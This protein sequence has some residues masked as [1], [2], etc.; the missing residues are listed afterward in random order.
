[1]SRAVAARATS[2]AI[3]FGPVP[4]DRQVEPH[5]PVEQGRDEDDADQQHDRDRRRDL[6]ATV[7]DALDELAARN[8]RPQAA[9]LAHRATCLPEDLGQA[10][11]AR[12]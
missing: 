8:D 5:R 11:A 6:E 2:R 4:D 3:T 10:S 7:A 1:M 9:I 12:R